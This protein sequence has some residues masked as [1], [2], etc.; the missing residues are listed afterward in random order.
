VSDPVAVRSGCL[1]CDFAVIS[2]EIIL[3][4]LSRLLGVEADWSIPRSPARLDRKGRPRGRGHRGCWLIR[5]NGRVAS[6]DVNEH[7]RYLLSILLPH[8]EAIISAARG[9]VASFSVYWSGPGSPL[10]SGPRLAVDCVVG[11]AE[12]RAGIGLTWRCCPLQWTPATTPECA[13]D[14]LCAP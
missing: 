4:D 7:L 9:G 10:Q 14:E 12:L 5:S 2:D 11:I 13:S 6:G 3:E 8:R 1:G